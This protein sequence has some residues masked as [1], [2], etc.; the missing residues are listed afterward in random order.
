MLKS[1][2]VRGFKSLANVED[3]ELAPFTL[4]FGPNAAG[5][6][7]LIDALQ[8]LS[9]LATA[10]TV[11]EA[12]GPPVRG[13][14]LEAFTFPE[15]GLP[16]LLQSPEDT[17]PRF[18]LR[19][20]IED[21]EVEGDGYQ[22]EVEISI[23]PRSGRLSVTDERIARFSDEG[24]PE[25][26]PV[27]TRPAVNGGL[28]P[29]PNE[30]RRCGRR[31]RVGHNQTLLSQV[32]GPDYADIAQVRRALGAFR[33]YYL[34]PRTAM[35]A[36]QP[37]Q[38]VDD[39][40]TLGEHIAPFLYRLRSEQPKVFAAVRRSLCMLIPSVEDLSVDLDPKQG[41]LDVEIKQQGVSYWSRVMSE[42][43]LRVLA[44]ACV[45]TNPWAGSAVAIEEPEN[46]VDPR[47]VELIAQMLGSLALGVSAK[48][49]QVIVATHSPIFC[50]AI[51][52]LARERPE[53]VRLYQVIREGQHT[54]LSS[55]DP[56][57][58]LFDDPQIAQALTAPMEE[59]WRT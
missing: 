52:R 7:N 4:F 30:R 37:P 51:V 42:G 9:R 15:G 8:V 18:R 22:Y 57:G 55:F 1:L 54:R 35:R 3:I 45:A 43:T 13:L 41:V 20:Q 27:L 38:E 26:E 28:E 14:P 53:S 56:R 40:G 31:V 47:R 50:G 10:D 5:K 58:P 21:V 44:L 39:I 2:S 34:D 59:V 33:S 32:S 24:A 23:T 11:A 49:R 19:A 17:P 36:T 16:A 6:S 25:W 29:P 12:L 48:Q 46:G